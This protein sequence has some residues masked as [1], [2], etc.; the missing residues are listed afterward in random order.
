MSSQ[1]VMSRKQA[2]NNP[3]LCHIKG[4]VGFGGDLLIH[5]KAAA[6]L[7]MTYGN[8]LFIEQYCTKLL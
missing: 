5:L 8:V 3:G 7:N 6:Y 2:N 4:W 1:G